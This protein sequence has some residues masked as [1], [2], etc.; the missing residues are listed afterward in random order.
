MVS[1]QQ[2]VHDDLERSRG[3]YEWVADLC[4]RLGAAREDLVPF[5]K[6]A[7]AAVSLQKPSSAARALFGGAPH[8]ERVDRLVR[9]IAAQL[10]LRNDDFQEIV[11]LVDTR[12]RANRAALPGAA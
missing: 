7:Q 9:R 10:H 8:I 3:I 4:C 2:A 11:E 5:E 1:I 6:Y 12:L